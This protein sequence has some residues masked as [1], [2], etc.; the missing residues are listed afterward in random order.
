MAVPKINFNDADCCNTGEL[1]AAGNIKASPGVVFWISACETAGTSATFVLN[2]ATSGTTGEIATFRVLANTTL[3]LRF[4]PAVYCATGIRLG[5]VGSN[6]SITVG[7]A[8]EVMIE[9]NKKVFS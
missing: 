8:Q 4:A 6:M 1:T 3:A 9:R 7:Y 5:T 2:D